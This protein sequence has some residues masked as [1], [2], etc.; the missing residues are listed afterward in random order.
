MNNYF[1]ST[2]SPIGPLY[3]VSSDKAIQAIIF[4]ESW[5]TYKA[6]FKGSLEKKTT[7][8]ITKAIKQ[9]A[10]YFNGQ[11]ATFQ[12]PLELEGTPFQLKAWKSLQTIPFGKTISYAEQAK[13]V[14]NAKAFR[15][16]GGANNKNPIAIV[17][18]CHRVIGKSGALVGYGGGLSAKEKLLKMETAHS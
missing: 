3:I 7:A 18:P 14:G 2:K 5:K 10:E 13:R 12:L 15:A 4:E 16:V 17:I 11:R 8:P 6:N 9:L 1:N